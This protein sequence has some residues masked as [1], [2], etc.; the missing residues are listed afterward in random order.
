M[1]YNDFKGIKLSALGFGMMRL[2][3]ING[4]NSKIDEEA[5]KEMIDYAIKNGVNYFDTAWGY[6]GENS[7]TVAGKYLS[8]YP[9]ESYYLATKFPGYDTSNFG[10]VEEIFERQLEKCKTDYFDFY[11]LHNLYE[12]NFEFYLNDEKYKTI[13]YL[14]EQKKKGRIKYLG[15]S[16]HSNN[17][18]FE[19]FLN[20]VGEHLDFCQIQLNYLDWD[21]QNAKEKV[22]ILNERNIPIWVMEPLRGGKLVNLPKEAEDKLRALKEDESPVSWAFR[23][24][25]SVPGVNVI[26]SGMSDMEQL[27]DN[28]KI[29]SEKRLINEK[30]FNCLISIA[31]SIMG[32]GTYPCTG[33]KYCVSHCPIGLDIPTMIFLYN[34]HNFVKDGFMAPMAIGALPSEKRP[35]ACLGCKSCEAVCPQQIQIAEA[36]QKLSEMLKLK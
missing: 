12:G 33:C 24:L 8:Q 19:D 1:M 18:I 34:E 32:K 21:F 26:L 20:K 4:E 5:T 6:H 13:S 31:H 14:L 15:M 23:F 2:P 17:E 28:I 36:M 27:K 9:R 29:F 10:K 7:E 30:E 25:Q 35:N 16:A 22:R 11:L 3:V